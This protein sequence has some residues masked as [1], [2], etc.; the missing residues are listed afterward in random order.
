[1]YVPNLRSFPLLIVIP[2]MLAACAVGTEFVRPAPEAI[3]VG[4]STYNQVIEHFGKPKDETRVRKNDELL[5]AISYTYANDMESAK[6]PNT[7]AARNIFFLF[8]GEVVVAEEFNSSFASDSTDFDQ[9]KVGDIV[10]GKTR[11]E[12]VVQMLGRPAGKAIYPAI[13][14]RGESAIVYG[15]SYVKRP[16]LQ[17]KTYSKQL[18]VVCDSGGV[19]TDVS[20]VEAG[21]P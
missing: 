17:F 10:K 6:V 7:L 19:V 14:K 11:C 15:F 4:K 9:R 18:K 2:F 21:D 16:L 1:M 5:R 13:D 12:E 3:E 20:Y 8:L